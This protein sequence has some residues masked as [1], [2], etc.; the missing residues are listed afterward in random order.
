MIS[1]VFVANKALTKELIEF[2]IFSVLVMLWAMECMAMS[3]FGTTSRII[4]FCAIFICAQQL[5]RI[6]SMKVKWRALHCQAMAFGNA[7][8]LVVKFTAC[9]VLAKDFI[10]SHFFDHC[11]WASVCAAHGDLVTTSIPISIICA[12]PYI[13]KD[14]GGVP[15]CY[16]VLGAIVGTASTI[17]GTAFEDVGVGAIPIVAI[18]LCSVH[19][20]LVII[21]ASV[22]SASALFVGA[23]IAVVQAT[24]CISAMDMRSIC[25]K[26]VSLWGF[27]HVASGD[28]MAANI[29]ISI[30]T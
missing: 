15:E 11:V 29:S 10:R 20:I 16:V 23:S 30:Y 18:Y 24:R 6:V 13:A 3:L 27:V 19:A 4:G 17:Q 14:L 9:P 2:E 7:T 12:Q 1:I 26:H 22:H 25:F 28:S 8:S 21:W 5:V